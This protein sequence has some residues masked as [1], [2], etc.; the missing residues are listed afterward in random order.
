[1]MTPPLSMAGK[2]FLDISAQEELYWLVAGAV[3]ARFLGHFGDE[4]ASDE[5]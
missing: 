5:A 1:M 2:P 4:A 3:D